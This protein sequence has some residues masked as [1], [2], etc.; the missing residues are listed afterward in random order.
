MK[1]RA[2]H[3]VPLSQQALTVLN[4]LKPITGRG[5]LLFPNQTTPKTCMSEN[6]LLYALYRMGQDGR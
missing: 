5:S 3:V 2:P 6:T 4:Q 1:M